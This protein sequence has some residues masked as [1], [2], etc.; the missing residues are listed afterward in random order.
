MERS[1]WI[2]GENVTNHDIRHFAQR[3]AVGSGAAKNP[4]GAGAPGS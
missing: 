4:R 1:F 2:G 3:A